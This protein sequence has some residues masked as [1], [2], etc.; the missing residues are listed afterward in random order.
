VRLPLYHDAFTIQD[1]L[2]YG[3]VYLARDGSGLHSYTDVENIIR[4]YGEYFAVGR[5]SN[6][7]EL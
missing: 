1:L 6:I 5:S 2:A 7:K 4:A 3:N